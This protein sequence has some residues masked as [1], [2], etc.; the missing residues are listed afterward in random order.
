MRPA[1][2]AEIARPGRGAD[3]R[4]QGLAGLRGDAQSHTSATQ[5]HW[6]GGR[7]KA[8]LRC[9]WAAAGPG[10]ASRSTTPSRQARVWRSRGRAAAHRHTERPDRTRQ[11]MRSGWRARR[12]ELA[13]RTARGRAAAHGRSEQAG[14]TQHAAPGTPAALH[15]KQSRSNT[16]KNARPAT[17]VHSFTATLPKVI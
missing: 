14:L 6:C 2:P 8:W 15:R 13:A 4:W 10:R 7:R 5:P 17:I 1:R 11:I 16:T 3:G 12:A 9:P